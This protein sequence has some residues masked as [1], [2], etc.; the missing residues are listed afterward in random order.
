M[1]IEQRVEQ[2]ERQVNSLQASFIQSQ[3]NQVPITAKTDSTA[4]RVDVVEA[5]EPYIE[6]KT[7][8]I[9]DDHVVFDLVRDG[10]VSVYMV[11]GDGKNVEH[12]FDRENGQIVV[13]FEKRDSLATVTISIQ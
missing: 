1:T 10:N 5:N 2:L 6:S 4:N 8:Y 12:T 13:S 9:D 11:D 3:K 7:A